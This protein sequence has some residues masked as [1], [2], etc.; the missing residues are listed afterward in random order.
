MPPGT[1]GMA[2]SPS[3]DYSSRNADG[4]LGMRLTL[5]R[6]FPKGLLGAMTMFGSGNTTGHEG[7]SFVENGAAAL[8]LVAISLLAGLSSGLAG[9]MS[10][11]GQ[12]AVNQTGAAT[13][14][15]PIAVPPGTAGVVPPLSLE[16]SSQGTNG[17]LGM[18]WTLG[19]LPSISRCPRTMVQ[20]GA[21]GGVNFDGNDRF[22]MEGQRLSGLG[23]SYGA[24]GTQYRTEV[25]SY[26]K[27][28]SHGV[29]GTGPAWFE[30]HTKSGQV[31]EFGNSA[32]SQI[33]AQGKSTVRVWALSKLSDSKGN[34]FTVVYNDDAGNV[35]YSPAQINYTGNDV[36]GLVASNSVQFSYATRSDVVPRYQAGS[37]SQTG[38][39]LAQIRTYT[40]TT[41]VSSYQLNYQTGRTGRSR[42]ASIQVCDGA[43][44]PNCMPPTSLAWT[45]V[46]QSFSTAQDWLSGGAFAPSTGWTDMNTYPRFIADLNGDGLPD[47]LGLYNN[48]IYAALNSSSSFPGVQCW[49]SGGA[50]AP[51]TGWTD[52]NTY[53]RFVAD[54][55]GDGLPDILG[56][57]SN[58]IFVALNSGSGF[59]GVQCWLS[60]GAFQA[61]WPDMNTAP[62][63]L[64]DVTGDGLPDIVAI[65]DSCLYVAPNSGSGFPG[66]QCWLTGG[67]F[68]PKTGWTDMNTFRASCST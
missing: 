14:T 67:A 59:P 17:L 23:G 58:C 3:L 57:Y 39:L 62:R 12:F 22:C 41:L 51:S 40:G 36:A 15:I 35:G 29:A 49:L 54:L 26:S 20:D 68:A 27:L 44:S 9:T 43:A 1:T 4:L 53:P 19:G 37:K 32:S 45:D 28:I 8:V 7:W 2:P 56:L 48:C 66:I 21:I 10:L 13:Y 33:L 46:P 60:G 25:D 16:Y 31:L 64:V 30:V 63:F 61:G 18:G 34:Y 11:S 24:D 47:I 42:L 38:A 65:H 5:L 55:N 52:M 50:F 6:E